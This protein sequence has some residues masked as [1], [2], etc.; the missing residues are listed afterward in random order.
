VDGAIA[1]L[2]C[3]MGFPSELGNAFFIMARVAGVVAHV[4]EE[5]TTMRPMRHI[6]SKEH[7]YDGVPERTFS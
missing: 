4:F 1:A 5:Q 3:E 6:N 2:L 7:V